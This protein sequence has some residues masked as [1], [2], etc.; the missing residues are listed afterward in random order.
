MRSRGVERLRWHSVERP[1]LLSIFSATRVDG[2]FAA[3]SLGIVTTL[4]ASMGAYFQAGHYEAL[5]LKYRETA[6]ALDRKVA[7]FG[8]ARSP[9]N[10]QQFVVDAET[11][12]QAENAAWL[13]EVTAKT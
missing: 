4:A 9:Q 8:A 12:M 3:A 1:A 2:T 13:N 10:Q 7:E 11:L 5:A 6:D